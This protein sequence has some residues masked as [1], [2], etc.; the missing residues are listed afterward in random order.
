MGAPRISYQSGY[1]YQLVEDYSLFV[2]ITP[3]AK[4]VC[5]DTKFIEL[6]EDGLL[7]I[8]AGYAWDGPSGPAFDTPTFMRASLVHDALYQLMREK[9]LDA[10]VHR[11]K[12]DEILRD[13]CKEDGMW[14]ARVWWV[15]KA[16]RRA[17]GP[18]ADARGIKPILYAPHQWKPN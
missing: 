15:Y 18:A 11:V 16:V 17:A 9:H 5:I 10:A 1:K 12:A 6:T 4:G 13:L 3:P 8:R 2:G 14:A 7:I